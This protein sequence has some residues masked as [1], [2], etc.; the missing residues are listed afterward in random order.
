MASNRSGGRQ[1]RTT[2][3]PEVGV[4]E[5]SLQNLRDLAREFGVQ[6]YSRMN[7]DELYNVLH[8]L[9][10]MGFDP[11][12]PINFYSTELL[13]R[14][15]RERFPGRVGGPRLNR[16]QLYDALIAGG[17]VGAGGVAENS[18]GL[19]SEFPLGALGRRA[20]AAAAA[21]GGAAAA[22]PYLARNVQEL[23]QMARDRKLA[24]WAGMSQRELA[25]QLHGF[26]Q[27]SN[28][29]KLY[30]RGQR[31][32][33]LGGNAPDN[34]QFEPSASQLEILREEIVPTAD[35]WQHALSMANEL[36]GGIGAAAAGKFLSPI[37][38]ELRGKGG[39][40]PAATRGGARRSGGRKAT[41]GGRV[42]TGGARRSGGRTSAPRA[43]REVR[44]GTFDLA[45]LG[46][47]RR[48]RSGTFDLDELDTTQSTFEPIDSGITSLGTHSLI[49]S[50]SRGIAG[51]SRSPVRSLSGSSA[52]ELAGDIMGG[53]RGR[54]GSAG[55][56]GRAASPARG[57]QR[58]HTLWTDAFTQLANARGISTSEAMQLL[59][60]VWP[61]GLGADAPLPQEIFTA[62][63]ELGVNYRQY[64][65]GAMARTRAAASG[66]V[67][68][69]QAQVPRAANRRSASPLSREKI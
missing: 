51:G 17:D 8:Q 52:D 50:G 56:G 49:R 59:A 5:Y 40:A 20:Q 57:V 34:G 13:R 67:G 23:K 3:D 16:Q 42:A 48:N 10:G 46:T 6:G 63:P 64:A 45:D 12:F 53:G 62:F 1:A 35:N 24:G 2:F 26:D 55:R 54:A 43:R 47:G 66:A 58:N 14:L 69:T 9:T 39:R 18:P 44:Q 15:V 19:G 37:W 36:F 4:R 60:P 27:G 32:G 33:R 22:N 25:A 28:E 31:P 41:S 30:P 61:E 21:G 38:Q 11:N 65:R 29:C 7:R 68:G